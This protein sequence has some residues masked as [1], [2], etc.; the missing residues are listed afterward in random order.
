MCDWCRFNVSHT[1]EGTPTREFSRGVLNQRREQQ[2]KEVTESH[3]VKKTDYDTLM[4][5]IYDNR[6]RGYWSELLVEDELLKL[7]L[8]NNTKI[9]HPTKGTKDLA[10][11]LAG[12]VFACA[13]N[14]N[15]DTEIEIEIVN[16]GPG[17]HEKYE[18]EKEMSEVLMMDENSLAWESTNSTVKTMPSELQ[19]WFGHV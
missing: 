4:T 14:I 19:E 1:H 9:D 7:K 8:L 13:K 3:G 17:I 2:V 6:L 18:H 5:A 15:M 10:D 12:A 16:T 11:S